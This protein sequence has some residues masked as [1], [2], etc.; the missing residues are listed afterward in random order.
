M[1]FYETMCFYI[2]V[3]YGAPVVR[4]P[5]VRAPVVRSPVVRSPVVR[6]PVVRSPVVRSPVVRSPVVRALPVGVGVGLVAPP[7]LPVQFAQGKSNY[8][9]ASRVSIQIFVHKLS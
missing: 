6:A 2:N 9:S 1:I 3:A 8:N 4:S 7:V 5:V